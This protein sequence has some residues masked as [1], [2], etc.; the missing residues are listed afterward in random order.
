MSENIELTR[1]DSLNQGQTKLNLQNLSKSTIVW[2][3]SFVSLLILACQLP[4][5]IS[6]SLSNYK[7]WQ[8]TSFNEQHA[9]NYLVNLT[10]FGPR[11]SSTF[12]NL[13]ARDYLLAQI[14]E[15]CSSSLIKRRCEINLQNLNEFDQNILVRISDFN[16]ANLSSLL[17]VAH[18]DSVEFSEGSS[19]DGVGI[20]V[21]LELLSNLV[22]DKLVKFSNLN[23]IVMFTNSEERG[24][25]GAKAFI[26]NHS[27][28][29][30][31]H[32]FISIDAV[33]CK[34]RAILVDMKPSKVS[35]D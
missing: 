18:Y 21:L 1:L 22:N 2:F 9:F 12:A 30:D 15:I 33:V 31:V 13:Q 19:D 20:V 29:L 17:L 10:K 23:L 25:L 4:I 14:N 3:F 28:H 24:L 7:S 8:S 26:S 16:S 27:W 11:V 32:R 35:C 34:D 5:Y 6:P